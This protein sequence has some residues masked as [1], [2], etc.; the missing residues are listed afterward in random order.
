M[1]SWRVCVSTILIV[2]VNLVLVMILQPSWT[3]PHLRLVPE[4]V[5]GEA[6]HPTLTRRCFSYSG[7]KAE[8]I[9][10]KMH[11]YKHEGDIL[12]CVRRA[13]VEAFMSSRAGPNSRPPEPR[14]LDFLTGKVDWAFPVESPPERLIG[15][16]HWM[17]IGDSYLRYLFDV[18]ARRAFGPGLQY[19]MKDTKGDWLPA[20]NLLNT[21]RN[22]TIHDIIEVRH[23]A[24]PFR[25]TYYPD[26]LLKRVP[27][28][29]KLWE[30][31]PHLKPSVV[32]MGTGL[33]WMLAAKTTYAESGPDAAMTNVTQHFRS[34]VPHLS[35]LA[36][37][38]PTIFKL[39]DDVQDSHLTEKP[40][41]SA[42][43]FRRYNSLFRESLRDTGVFVWD[44][45]LPLSEAYTKECLITKAI[46]L[47]FSWRC[48]DHIHSGYIVQEQ[49]ADMVF[50]FICNKRLDRPSDYCT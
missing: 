27:E 44:S 47:D 9:C 46:T 36:K 43:I 1:L 34:L 20:A 49:F 24:A 22:R 42:E 33:H 35:R 12:K 21:L 40:E 13:N 31:E 3:N 37:T 14:D 17:I 18:M 8:N 50:N 39:L 11:R 6:E 45:N 4:I 10:C 26:F 29:I 48:F 19:R 23:L 2:G 7:V 32:V 15:T 30:L 16:A 5:L 28:L 38:T 41:Y 25:I